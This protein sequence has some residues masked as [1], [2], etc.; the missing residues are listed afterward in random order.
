VW[1]HGRPGGVS[2]PLLPQNI[3]PACIESK[4]LSQRRP[5]IGKSQA[6]IWLHFLVC[7]KNYCTYWFEVFKLCKAYASFEFFE[8]C[9]GIS[10]L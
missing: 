9:V 2:S 7:F 3:Y 1:G 4:H 5:F 8:A 6:L 10:F